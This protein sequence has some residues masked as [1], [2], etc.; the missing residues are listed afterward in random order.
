MGTQL[1]KVAQFV[2]AVSAIFLLP[3]STHALVMHLLSFL[4]SLALDMVSLDRYGR[5]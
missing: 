5:I 4:Q 2:Y 1:R 3:V